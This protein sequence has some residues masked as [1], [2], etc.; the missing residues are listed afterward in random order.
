MSDTARFLTFLRR[1]IERDARKGYDAA[2]DR[3]R[4]RDR[5]RV[6]ADRLIQGRA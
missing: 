6:L 3:Q 4:L 2:L 1:A 5:M